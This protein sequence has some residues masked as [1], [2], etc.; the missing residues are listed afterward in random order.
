MTN[1]AE[2]K[3]YVSLCHC[4]YKSVNR[5]R[6]SIRLEE[7]ERTVQAF[8]GNQPRRK[9]LGK[10]A[11]FK[12]SANTSSNFYFRHGPFNERLRQNVFPIS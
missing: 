10:R 1:G 4:C 9:C 5:K 6:P 2:L 7:M 8:L 3:A 11:T 12:G